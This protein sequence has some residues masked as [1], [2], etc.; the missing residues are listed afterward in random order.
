[1]YYAISSI[2]YGRDETT[3]GAVLSHREYALA[4]KPS[5]V[6]KKDWAARLNEIQVTVFRT[7]EGTTGFVLEGGSTVYWTGPHGTIRRATD[8]DIVAFA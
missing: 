5:V 7:P 3:E 4:A 2:G 6:P 1:M 8:D